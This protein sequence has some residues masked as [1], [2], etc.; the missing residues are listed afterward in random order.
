MDLSL[1]PGNIQAANLDTVLGKRLFRTSSALGQIMQLV[2]MQIPPKNEELLADV[3]K[4]FATYHLESIEETG[5][6]LIELS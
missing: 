5:E 6:K 1:R 3:D 2:K 4:L